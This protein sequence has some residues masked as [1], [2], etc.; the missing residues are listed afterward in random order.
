M[1]KPFKGFDFKTRP[2]IDCKRKALRK[3]EFTTNR[4]RKLTKRTKFKKENVYLS[5]I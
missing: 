3:F 4:H 1:L 5:E 2:K